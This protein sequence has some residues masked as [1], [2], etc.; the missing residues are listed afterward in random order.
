M[1]VMVLRK[2][3]EKSGT[4]L[5]SSDA[6]TLAGSVTPGLVETVLWRMP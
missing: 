1:K 6:S 3:R 5:P 2:L 4:Y